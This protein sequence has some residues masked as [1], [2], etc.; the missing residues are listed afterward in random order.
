MAAPPRF[1][2]LVTGASVPEVVTRFGGFPALFQ[3]HLTRGFDPDASPSIDAFDLTAW[4]GAQRNVDVRRYDGVVVTG[5]PARIGDMLP[6]MRYGVDLLAECV[7]EGV[8]LLAVCFG[9]QMLGVAMGA[10][11]GPNPPGYTVGTVKVR[12]EAPEGD[13]LLSPLPPQL[14]A[15]VSHL[16]AIRDP[17]PRLDVVGSCAH[18]R[19][20]IVKAG[21]LAWGVQLHPEFDGEIV[22]A[23]IRARA[24]LVEERHGPGSAAALLAEATDAPEA[25]SLIERFAHL[26]AGRRDGGGE[27]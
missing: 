6:W 1:L 24:A 4:G 3:D 9:H 23:Y 22:R 27:G 10:D 19:C 17:G 5:S 13:E 21:P 18:D 7:G 8:P 25:A 16:D 12:L 15:N 26:A 2:L 11:V 14:L 20:H